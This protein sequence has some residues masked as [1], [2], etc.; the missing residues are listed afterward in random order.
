MRLSKGLEVEIYTGKPN[1]EIIGFA[2]RI[3][4]DLDGFVREPDNRNV[5]YTT[6][7]YTSYERLL[8]AIVKPR[9]KL[10]EYLKTMGDYTLIPGSTLS[11][12]DTKT[13]YRSDLHN[14]YHGY[15][16]Q[17]YHTQVV[18]ASVHINIGIDDPELLMKACRLIRVEA[19]LFLA[20][21]ASSPFLDHQTT[22]FHSTRWA[23]FPKT[24]QVVPLF[25][26]HH[27]FI[28]WTEE[29]LQLG[30][31]QNIRHLWCSVRPNGD[32]RPYNLNRLELRIC[33]LVVDPM[34][35]LAI[36]AFLEAR[37]L[38][39]FQEGE[40]LDPVKVST[41]SPQELIDISDRNEQLASTHSLDAQLTHW[42]DGS[43]ITARDWIEGI[44]PGVW[45]VAQAAGFG[46]FLTPL[47]SILQEGN[48]AEQWLQSH[49]QGSSVSEIL[50]REIT[51][52][53]HQEQQ[54][55]DR[56]CQTIVI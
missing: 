4:R 44:Y 13:F 30:T 6:A 14:P 9:L 8:C 39:L 56:L 18:T 22:G 53:H 11:T 5:E 33:D 40:L 37:L 2:D 24:P 12:G 49:H 19:P 17:T 41:F 29:Q 50:Q 27:H 15:I 35:L 43:T 34:A 36:V 20:L 32:H 3:V 47:T 42:R 52:A 46:Q 21:S 51:I 28:E 16:E 55:E 31:M 25:L 26:S 1:G 23:T 7:P 10:R 54:L 45:Q 48:M 38:Q